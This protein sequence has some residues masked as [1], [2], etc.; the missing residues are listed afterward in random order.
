[1]KNEFKLLAVVPLEHRNENNKRLISLI[2]SNSFGAFEHIFIFD[3]T[4]DNTGNELVKA[5]ND[6][7]QKTVHVKASHLKKQRGFVF[8][9]AMLHASENKLDYIVM[10]N[11]GWPDNL[12]QVQDYL[13]GQEF[14][15]DSIAVS[16]RNPNKYNLGRLF[17][18]FSNKLST[19]SFGQKILDTKG[20]SINIFR[21]EDFLSKYQDKTF[22]LSDDSWYLWELMGQ[23][24]YHRNDIKFIGPASLN[25][26]GSL[27][28]LNL[29][30]FFSLI[31]K[32]IKF[33]L[34]ARKFLHTNRS[35]ISAYSANLS[36]VRNFNNKSLPVANT[37]TPEPIKEEVTPL[38]KSSK[39]PE[40]EK[41]K[42]DK[43]K[44]RNI[45]IESIYSAP[46]IAP[47]DIGELEIMR[48]DHFD[49]KN[50]DVI[51]INWC[52]TNICNFKCSYCPE[53]LHNGTEKGVEL[54]NIKKFFYKLKEYHPGREFFFEF[55][56]G[57]V[58]YYKQFPELIRFLKENGAHVGIISNGSRKISF[59]EKHH[60]FIDHICLSFHSEQGKADHFYDVV[61]YLTDK[62]TTHVNIMMKPET[63]DIC[64]DLSK[65]IAKDCEVSIAMQP[66]LENMDGALYN[67]SEAQKQILDKQQLEFGE[68]PK[69]KRQSN[70]EDNVY[71][72]AMRAMLDDFSST[73]YASPELISNEMNRWNGWECYAG[74]ENIVIG[75]KG[76]IMRGWCGVGGVIGNVRDENLVLPQKPIICNK[77]QCSCGLDIMCTKV[78][79]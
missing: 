58:T 40:A 46:I 68:E 8:K 62:M 26:P 73:V 38:P 43:S 7:G 24:S 3:T 76:Y 23:T 35:D 18:L 1:M 21:V 20:D 16:V 22:K 31:A 45:D 78:K 51:V 54:E 50:K 79:V 57:E 42:I 33:K 70:Y 10:F 71:R 27:I 69:Y 11:E 29:S 13:T 72:G 53:N 15:A 61:A 59:W 28:K 56:G 77:S 2:N 34:S 48:L 41:G 25:T 75:T 47:N 44:F 32:A 67:Y 66:L 17:N 65:R 14:V 55:T 30:R 39:K 52:L 6:K 9:K 64:Y 4:K 37:S 36:E 63:F 74:I 5:L 49:K 12:E 19:F 60:E